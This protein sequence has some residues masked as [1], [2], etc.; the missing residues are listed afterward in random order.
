MFKNK[1]IRNL[2]IIILLLIIYVFLSAKSYSSAVFNDL[3]NSVLRLHVIANSDD[4]SDQE[5]KYK[6]RDSVLAHMK[7]L[8]KDCKTKDE[9]IQILNEHL[10][11]F[12]FIAKKTIKEN[13][14]DYNV[15]VSISK[16]AFP[17][18][19]YGDISLPAG[20]Y[21][22]LKIEIGEAKGQNWW[23]VMFPPLCFVDVSSGVVPDESKEL[24]KDNLSNE[25]YKIISD[26]SK[27]VKIKFKI[28][29]LFSN[30]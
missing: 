28:L 26:T 29:E 11:E 6:V 24:L 4:T 3:S 25:D 21:D 19:Y 2:A 9:A 30:N 14:Y 8:S 7:E 12:S 1:F 15:N 16:C 17:T 27:D 22:A 18:K 10:Q 13:G 5:L 20:L 23:C